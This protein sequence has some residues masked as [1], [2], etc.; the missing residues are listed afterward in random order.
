MAKN[1][2]NAAILGYAVLSDDVKGCSVTAPDVISAVDQHT[3]PCFLFATRTDN[4]VPVA[5]SLRFMQALDRYGIAFESHIYA[6]GPHGFSTAAPAIQGPVPALCARTANWVQDS[7]GWLRDVL[8]G[9]GPDGYTAP[10]CPAHINDDYEAFLS[11]DCTLGHLLQN[12]SAR[13]LLQPILRA[14]FAGTG[15]G[16]SALSEDE[17]LSFAAPLKLRDALE[18]GHISAEELQ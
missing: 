7:I 13:T 6:F 9:F 1:R 4:V 5:N 17:L 8:G 11:V 12:P 3:C 18:F 15:A 16:D 14:A 10:V 2:P